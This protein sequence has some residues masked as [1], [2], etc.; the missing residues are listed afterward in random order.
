M[1]QDGYVVCPKECIGVA[2]K[3]SSVE[4]NN[5]GAFTL[6]KTVFGFQD[7]SGISPSWCEFTHM[8]ERK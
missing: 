6:L 5:Q 2:N 3:G 8:E 4:I 7:T 1:W